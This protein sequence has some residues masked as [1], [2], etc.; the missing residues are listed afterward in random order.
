MHFCSN[1]VSLRKHSVTLLLLLSTSQMLVQIV[2]HGSKNLSPPRFS[3][4]LL[5]LIFS[6]YNNEIPIPRLDLFSNIG[7]LPFTGLLTNVA[8][9][10]NG[11]CFY[12]PIYTPVRL[13]LL[14]FKVSRLTRIYGGFAL[15]NF[16][17]V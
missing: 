1:E 13:S 12:K 3:I 8:N 17:G 9:R 14:Y 15:S 11:F 6:L 10:E 16:N 2:A 4:Y 5:L 7:R